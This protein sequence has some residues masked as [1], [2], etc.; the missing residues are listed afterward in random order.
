M[1]ALDIQVNSVMGL[2]MIYCDNVS[3][4]ITSQ[5]FMDHWLEFHIYGFLVGHNLPR[6]VM[7]LSLYELFNASK[8]LFLKSDVLETVD[9]RLV[10]L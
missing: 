5:L 3:T 8:L 1:M 9:E 6:Y 4:F 7:L 10:W 2:S